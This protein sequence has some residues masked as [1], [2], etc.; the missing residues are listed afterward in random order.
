[1]VAK[2]KTSERNNMSISFGGGDAVVADEEYQV[3][4]PTENPR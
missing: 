2:R 4:N 3:I 1:M